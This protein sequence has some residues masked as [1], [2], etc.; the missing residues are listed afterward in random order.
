MPTS[1]HS[2]QYLAAIF[3]A[4]LVAFQSTGWLLV[5]QGLQ[6][7]A[8]H[9]AQRSLSRMEKALPENTFHKDFFQKIK[10]GRKEIL[11]NGQLFDYRILWENSDSI[12]LALYHDQYEQGL[13]SALGQVFEPKG[14]VEA[15][16]PPPIAQWL[17]QCVGSAFL[18]PEK[19]GLFP[20]VE[21]RLQKHNFISLLFKAQF[22]P[23]VFAPPPEL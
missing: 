2:R 12:R 9:E 4:S 20:S 18:L 21:A 16:S 6:L 19:P 1:S 17:A 5:W 10:I 8:R 14:S 22:V 15:G 23:S 11:F 3:L 13:L 7:G